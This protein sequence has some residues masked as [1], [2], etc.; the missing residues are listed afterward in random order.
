VRQ[1]TAWR[2][3]LSQFLLETADRRR[4][5]NLGWHPDIS[6]PA[7]EYDPAPIRR[8]C[9]PKVRERARLLVRGQSLRRLDARELDVQVIVSPAPGIPGEHNPASIRR[10]RG[11]HRIAWIR[12]ERHKDGRRFRPR[13]E[14]RA[15][16]GGARQEHDCTGGDGPAP[17]TR[18]RSLR[19]EQ[20]TAL[21]RPSF[22]LRHQSEHRPA[23]PVH[24]AMHRQPLLALPA[25]HGSLGAIEPRGDVF[26]EPSRSAALRSTG[27]RL[28]GCSINRT[29]L[30][31]ISYPRCVPAPQ[32]SLCCG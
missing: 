14:Q 13:L 6:P 8:P 16:P 10:K 32:H 3:D 18:G 11:V 24:Q 30:S 12:R 27:A 26:Q 20:V 17:V 4:P 29:R 9:R 25:L 31:Q 7:E 15:H 2:L 23:L 19:R 28:E 21:P 22:E 1:N 5:D